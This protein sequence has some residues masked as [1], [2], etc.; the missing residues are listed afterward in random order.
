M[1]YTYILCCEFELIY[2]K[3]L[4]I[5]Y[6]FSSFFFYI[7]IEIF[8]LNFSFLYET[9]SSNSPHFIRILKSRDEE[10]IHQEY[11]HLLYEDVGSTSSPPLRNSKCN[12]IRHH[13]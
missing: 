1:L 11:F 9:F 12:M 3:Y 5:L 13:S 10:I 2:Q 8:L 4:A 7:S 6:A